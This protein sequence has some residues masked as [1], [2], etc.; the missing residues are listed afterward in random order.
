MGFCWFLNIKQNHQ[1]FCQHWVICCL[2]AFISPYYLISEHHTKITFFLHLP[3]TQNCYFS[4]ILST[5]I[6]YIHKDID[7]FLISFRF[8]KMFE[9][10]CF[11]TISFQRIRFLLFI[12]ISKYVAQLIKDPLKKCCY[13]TKVLQSAHFSFKGTLT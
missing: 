7:N 13:S 1:Q 10:L 4:Q 11:H 9:T 3:P 2:C 6:K 12:L 5:S 8:K